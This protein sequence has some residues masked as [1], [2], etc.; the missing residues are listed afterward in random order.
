MKKEYSY[1]ALLY[2][3]YEWVQYFIMVWAIRKEWIIEYGFPKGH[4]EASDT[5]IKDTVIREIE[6]ETGISQDKLL[7]DNFDDKKI[8]FSLQYE[9]EKKW[10]TMLK[11]S[12]YYAI[13]MKEIHHQ[14]VL[15]VPA[16]F[17]H[18]IHDIRI[19]EWDKVYTSLTHKDEKILF[20][21]WL[22]WANKL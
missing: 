8:A 9:I 13:E 11:T 3:R 2:F 1:G 21:E 18:E 6:E 15:P 19:I 5:C 4:P 10:E 12:T 20:K 17:V 7:V 22:M 14:T 16:D